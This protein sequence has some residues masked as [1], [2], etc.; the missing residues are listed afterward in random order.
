MTLPSMVISWFGCSE[1]PYLAT[2]SSSG[3]IRSS[4]SKGTMEL[5]ATTATVYSAG[6]A[7]RAGP[8]MF[9]CSV[10]ALAE[11]VTSAVAQDMATP[12]TMRSASKSFD[13]MATL[14]AP[15]R[16]QSAKAVPPASK[17]ARLTAPA[18]KVLESFMVVIPS[19]GKRGLAGWPVGTA[20]DS[21]SLARFQ[22]LSTSCIRMQTLCEWAVMLGE[23]ENGPRLARAV[24]RDLRC[25]LRCWRSGPQ[26]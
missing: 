7:V 8:W 12:L 14:P 11:T 19:A 15:W 9:L 18:V 13:R 25:W 23:N 20:R 6:F 17:A 26:P 4:F 2:R 21:W 10:V 3:R 22:R 16:P 1:A 5:L 24:D